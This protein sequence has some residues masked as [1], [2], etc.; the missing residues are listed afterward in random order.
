MEDSQDCGSEKTGKTRLHHPQYRTISLL[1]M[2]GRLVEA[3]IARR[4][5]FYKEAYRLPPKTQF[6][7]RRGR[8]TEQALLVL[9]DLID[10][11]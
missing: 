1:N 11:A 10:Q 5:S 3:V 9:A 7:G 2:L 6:G 8:T 4:L